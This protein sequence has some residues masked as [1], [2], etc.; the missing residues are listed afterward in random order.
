MP[1]PTDFKKLTDPAIPV[2]SGTV[3]TDDLIHT[4]DVSDTTSGAAGTSK[5]TTIQQVIDVV[6]NN[7][8]LPT[9]ASGTWTPTFGDFT[10]CVV[11]VTAVNAYYTRVD[12]I[13]TAT[14]LASIALDFSISSFGYC[15]YTV[16][17]ATA[18]NDRI[19]LGQLLEDETDCNIASNG[20]KMR[21]YSTSS[22][23]IG[24]V[25]FTFTFQYEI[26]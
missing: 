12:N 22:S 4:V 15:D 6:Q 8:V 7:L 1:T 5:R 9:L 10:G 23:D 13:V 16:P 26:N 3:A 11:G 14:I 21:F 17:V 20:N 18:N 19:G 2:Q 24:T 25:G